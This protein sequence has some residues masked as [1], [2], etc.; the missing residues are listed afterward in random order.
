[1]QVWFTPVY[2]YIVTPHLKDAAERLGIVAIDAVRPL[3]ELY[4]L[5]N[6]PD[7]VSIDLMFT[8]ATTKER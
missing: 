2:Y 3:V 5:A 4:S 6:V 7:A 1:M 8:K